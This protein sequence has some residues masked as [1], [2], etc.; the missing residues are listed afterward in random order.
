MKLS[1]AQAKAHQQAMDLVY[2][3]KTLTEDDK[4]F[5]LDGFQES[6]TE[7]NGLAGAFFTPWGLARDFSLEVAGSSLD[8]G[9]IIDLC[10]G[11]GML[12]FAC[13]GKH[14]RMVCVERNPSYVEVG[15]RIL[16]EAEWY[17]GDVFEI[18]PTLGIFDWAISNPPFGAI[19]ADSFVGNYSGAKFEYKV[20]ELASQISEFGAFILPQMS[21]PFRYSGQQ[22][23]RDEIDESCQRFMDQAGIAM[24]VG[25]GIDTSVYLRDW[26]GVSPL[27]EIVVCEFGE[28]Q[29]EKSEVQLDMW[30]AA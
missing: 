26:K 8:G 20:M 1:K 9:G 19:K 21:A 6:A 27:C 3:D 29:A 4:Q 2:S 22:N 24:E 18:A 11:I 23:Y 30:E 25:C 16:P 17:V 14:E 28:K 12:S 10:A 13:R 7:M 15:K 5:I